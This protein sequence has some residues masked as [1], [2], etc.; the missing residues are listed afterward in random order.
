MPIQVYAVRRFTP[1]RGD[2]RCF[3]LYVIAT[4]ECAS[5]PGTRKELEKYARQK[6]ATPQTTKEQQPCH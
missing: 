5:F 6:N 4:G 1:Y 3:E 2:R